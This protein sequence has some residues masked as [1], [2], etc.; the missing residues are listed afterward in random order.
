MRRFVWRLQRLLDTKGKQEDALRAELVAV[1]EQVVAVRGQI[2]LLR[3]TL[4]RL[5]SD[6]QDGKNKQWLFQKRLVL[7]HSQ[8]TELNIRALDKKLY[9]LEQ[10]RKQKIKEVMEVRKFRKSL[11]KLRTKAYEKHKQE[12]EKKEQNELDERISISFA[13]EILLTD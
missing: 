13:R 10:S 1:T 12:E 7:D 3:A 4:R 6:L 2:M 5:L 9:E 11:E 8:V